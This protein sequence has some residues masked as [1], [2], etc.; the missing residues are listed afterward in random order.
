MQKEIISLVHIMCIKHWGERGN[1]T[2]NNDDALH[3]P[4]N[5][6]LVQYCIM[7]GERL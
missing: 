7:R 6:E 2:R 5:C 1:V 4:G 3:S